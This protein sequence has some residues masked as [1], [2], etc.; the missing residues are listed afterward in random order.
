MK[1]VGLVTNGSNGVVGGFDNALTKGVLAAQDT[2]AN[3]KQEL[4]MTVVGLGLM[5][6]AKALCSDLE[7]MSGALD[8][9]LEL[10][11]IAEAG[12]YVGGAVAVLGA[13]GVAKKFADNYENLEEIENMDEDE[14]NTFLNT[15]G[16]SSKKKLET[17]KVEK[18]TTDIQ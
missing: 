3:S 13:T 17:L 18:L 15:R 12:V 7:F 14:F 1:L 2:L 16:M 11:D 9:Q 6:G 8:G 10:T 5:V 4:A